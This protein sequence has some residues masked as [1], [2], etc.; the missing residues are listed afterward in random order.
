MLL[1][2]ILSHHCEDEWELLQG[3]Y[4]H[5]C[6]PASAAVA[7]GRENSQSEAGREA[8]QRENSCCWSIPDLF[9][10]HLLG[11]LCQGMKG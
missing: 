9:Q 6:H 10:Q 7:Q 8:I 2:T 11:S 1:G 5:V 4:I 3:C